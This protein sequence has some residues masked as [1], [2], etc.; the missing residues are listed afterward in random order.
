MKKNEL[1]ALTSCVLFKGFSER[2]VLG[3]VSLTSYRAETFSKR[4]DIFTPERFTRS[5]AVIL[6]GSAEVF[7]P[8]SGA[9]ML[10]SILVPGDVFG[11]P[12]VFC[13]EKPFPTEVRAREDCRVLFIPKEE[14]E[15]IFA[16]YPAAVYNYIA[17]LSEKI[18]YLNEKIERLASPGAD[19]KLKLF[20]ENT[21]RKAGS[22][23]FIL[24]VSLSELAS[25]LSVG[26]TSLY[27]AMD[28]LTASGYLKRDGRKIR[29]ER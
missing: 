14:L 29:L 11:L 16:A 15:A 4:S 21:A 5:L 24:P 28:E 10:M 19:E 25:S 7:K 2:D 27:R 26:R 6:K 17:V 23:E 20:L 13:G 8:S 3:A 22:D 18:H 1:A 9:P 12:S